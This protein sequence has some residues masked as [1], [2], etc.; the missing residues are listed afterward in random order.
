MTLESVSDDKSV[1]PAVDAM[2]MAFAEDCNAVHSL[3]VNRIPCNQELAD[4]IFIQVDQSPVLPEGNFAVGALGLVN[5]VLAAYGLP[6]L[7]TK[8]SEET[9]EDGRSRLMGFCEYKP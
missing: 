8:W 4:D 9:D 7:A 6:L 2:N 3:I 5:G 1:N